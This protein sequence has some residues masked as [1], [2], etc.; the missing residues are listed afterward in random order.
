MIEVNK[1]YNEDCRDTMA[2]MPD[3]SVDCIVTDPPYQLDSTRERWGKAN[4]ENEE[5]RQAEIK[6]GGTIFSRST[7]GFMGLE[8][9]VLPSVEIWKACLRVL[10]PGAFAFVFCTPRQDSLAEMIV[11]L[12]QAG[13][14]IGFSSIYWTYL[15]GFPKAQNISLAIDKRECKKQLEK[16]LGREPT[17]KEFKKEW[18]GFREVIGKGKGHTGKRV[19]THSRL[20]DDDNYEWSGDYTIT[21]PNT[22]KAQYFNGWFTNS[23]KPATEIIIVVQKSLKQTD[24]H[25]IKL[26]FKQL[27]EMKKFLLAKQR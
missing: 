26:D 18:K 1:I 13:F 9:D 24:K 14:E 22:P 8:W 4:L 2:K 20:F 12:K 5:Y 7:K 25:K 17:K 23:A 10:K 19:K 6:K 21:K 3:N 11:R 16:K 27:K 15:T